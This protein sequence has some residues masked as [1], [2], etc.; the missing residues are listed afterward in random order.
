MIK[1][2]TLV[3]VGMAEQKCVN[4]KVHSKSRIHLLDRV[5]G[6]IQGEKHIRGH[7]QGSSQW[8]AGI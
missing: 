6:C 7:I 1:R 5:I 8:A 4:F 2:K 3:F